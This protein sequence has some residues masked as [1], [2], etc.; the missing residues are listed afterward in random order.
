M[1][2]QKKQKPYFDRFRKNV[3]FKP[4]DETLNPK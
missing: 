2:T 1:K 4:G 3:D